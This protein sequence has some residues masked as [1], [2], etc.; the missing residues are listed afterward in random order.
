M[1]E[2]V[3]WYRQQLDDDRRAAIHMT[4]WDDD[5]LKAIHDPDVRRYVNQVAD[6]ETV[7]ADVA[8]KRAILDSTVGELERLGNMPPEAH[9]MA[10]EVVK[11]LASAYRHRPGWKQE[12]EA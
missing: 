2:L 10:D 1:D 7:L 11:A 5:L 3:A 6:P 9:I 8:A 4:R 12:W